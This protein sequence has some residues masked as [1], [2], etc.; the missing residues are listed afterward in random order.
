LTKGEITDIT[1]EVTGNPKVIPQAIK[2]VKPL[3]KFILLSSPRGPSLL[4]FHDEVNAPSRIIIG[5]HFSSQP[6]YETPY[7]PWTRKKKY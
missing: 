6:V 4:D 3:G 5:T 7:N 2:L 1:F